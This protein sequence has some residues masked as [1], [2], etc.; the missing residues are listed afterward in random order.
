MDD[1]LSLF[2]LP[3]YSVV[4]KHVKPTMR[5]IKIWVEGADSDRSV[6][7]AQATTYAY[8]NSVLDHI[9]KGVDRVTCKHK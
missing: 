5:T 9:N 1:H 7:A 2:L 8:T 3:K 6:L 4:F